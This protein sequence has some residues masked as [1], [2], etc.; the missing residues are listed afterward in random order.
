[1]EDIRKN[2][3]KNLAI[4][5]I[6]G[7]LSTIDRCPIIPCLIVNKDLEGNEH[8]DFPCSVNTNTSVI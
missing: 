8:V 6:T 7:T 2:S 3:S 4:M 1:L 5:D